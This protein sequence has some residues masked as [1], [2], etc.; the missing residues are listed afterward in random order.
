[1][2]DLIWFWIGI[3]GGIVFLILVLP[4]LVGEILDALTDAL[5]GEVRTGKVDIEKPVEQQMAKRRE[6]EIYNKTRKV[7]RKGGQVL[8]SEIE[9]AITA[10]PEI[11]EEGLELIGNQYSTSVGYIDILCRDR[12]GD[13]VVIELKRGRGSY[14]VVGQIQ[15]YMAWII[16]NIAND[17]QVRGIIVVKEYDRDLEYALKGSKFPITIKI[18]G[19]EPPT[20]ENIK[21]C[22]SCGKP[23]K[24]S[25]KYCEKC[26]QEFW[27]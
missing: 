15:K 27:M 9:S 17:K 22:D 10:N 25:A 8:E 4:W 21:Y 12:K 18:F 16:E 5:T 23:N 11:L 3:S 1:M 19:Q 6:M 7:E 13:L 2:D 14:N 26:G 20:E 24:K